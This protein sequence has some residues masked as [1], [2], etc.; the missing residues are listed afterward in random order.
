MHVICFNL[1]KHSSYYIVPLA[2]TLRYLYLIP[3]S[4]Y[5]FGMLLAVNSNYFPKLH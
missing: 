2:L 4:I 5:M 3:H 1:L